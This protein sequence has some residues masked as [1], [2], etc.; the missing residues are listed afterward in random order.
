MKIKNY[1]V[2]VSFLVFFL[3]GALLCLLHTPQEYSASERR[4]LKQFP[5]IT[6]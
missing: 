6:W 1:I 3:G 4:K 2:T 5:K